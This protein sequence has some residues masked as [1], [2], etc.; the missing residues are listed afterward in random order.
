MLI[1]TDFWP[2]ER[3]LFDLRIVPHPDIA[4][5]YPARWPGHHAPQRKARSAPYLTDRDFT[6]FSTISYG[7]PTSSAHGGKFPLTRGRTRCLEL[8][9]RRMVDVPRTSSTVAIV[10]G[11]SSTGR[12]DAGLSRLQD[13][14][15]RLGGCSPVHGLARSGV[16]CAQPECRSPRCQDP[17]SGLL[18]VPPRCAVGSL[19]RVPAVM[20]SRPTRALPLVLLR[21][22]GTRSEHPVRGQ[23][24][25]SR[26]SAP[27]PC[28]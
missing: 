8:E 26:R 2:F 21:A 27:Q 10:A 28:T 18:P 3:R 9:I 5:V 22:R 23:A 11:L 4:I 1:A 15:K 7:R 6:A 12:R 24:L 20:I 19:C 17:R 13:V 14:V 16:E 25:S